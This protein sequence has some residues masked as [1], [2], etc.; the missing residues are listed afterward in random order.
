MTKYVQE[1]GY[2]KRE[3][4]SKMMLA[5]VLTIMPLGIVR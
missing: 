4:A 3:Q 2:P 1:A 5:L